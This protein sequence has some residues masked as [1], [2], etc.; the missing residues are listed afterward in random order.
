[1]RTII[2]FS[3]HCTDGNPRAEPSFRREWSD[4][5]DEV[6]TWT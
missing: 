5:T 1:M 3:S 4:N 2:G 6:N